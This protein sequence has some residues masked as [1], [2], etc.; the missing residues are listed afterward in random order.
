MYLITRYSGE[1]CDCQRSVFEHH[2]FFLQCSKNNG[3]GIQS[4]IGRCIPPEN[5][6]FYRCDGSTVKTEI[7]SCTEHVT[8][9]IEFPSRCWRDK[10]RFCSIA[11]LRRYCDVPAFKRKCCRSC[12]RNETLELSNFFDRKHRILQT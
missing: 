9:A 11:S 12:E 5:E 4:R 6:S 7:R 8:R 1:K 10:N 3:K 2:I